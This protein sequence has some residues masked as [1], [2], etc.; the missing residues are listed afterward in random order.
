MFLNHPN[1][2]KLYTFFFD[3]KSIYLV[4]ELCASGQLFN[5]LKNNKLVKEQH[6]K[7]I[8]KQ[9]CQGLD[10]IHENHIIHRDLKPEN[11]LYHNV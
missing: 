7:V 5:F 10:Y 2:V 11:I 4:F 6:A 8:I 3:D 9:I 1:I